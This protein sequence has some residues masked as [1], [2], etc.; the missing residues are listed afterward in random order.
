MVYQCTG[1]ESMAIHPLGM[2]KL[3][4]GY[5]LPMGPPVDQLCK[6]C[7][8]KHHVSIHLFIYPSESNILNKLNNEII[9]VDAV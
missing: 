9:R 8:S 5:K 7:Q 6:F 4:G 1:C 3:N 2:K